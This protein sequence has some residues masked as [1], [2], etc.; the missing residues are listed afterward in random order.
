MKWFALFS[1][2]F[3]L[4]NFSTL[5][6][7]CVNGDCRSGLGT[8]I[9]RKT[10]SRYD[11]Q[12]LG[13]LRHGSGIMYFVNGDVYKGDWRNDKINGLGVFHA[14]NGDR[15]EGEFRDDKPH[16]Q[17]RLVKSNGTMQ[18]GRWVEGL[19]QQQQQQRTEQGTL[20]SS[21]SNNNNNNRQQQPTVYQTSAKPNG[22]TKSEASSLPD[23]TFSN[24]NNIRGVYYYRDGSRFEGM[25]KNGKPEGEGVC[26]YVNRDRYVG[27]WTKHAPHGQGILYYANGEVAGGRWHFGRLI[28][29]TSNDYLV[30]NQ[31]VKRDNDKSIK[32]W[33]VVIGIAR[34]S[35]M[36][37]LKYSDDD[38]YQ[39]YAFLKSPEGGAVP[40]KQIKVLIDEDATRAKILEGLRQT[41]LKADENDVVLIYYSG[42]G[43][44]GA[45]VPIDFDG[46]NNL[47]RHDEVKS[48]LSQ[49]QAKHK[50]VFADACH[51]G[52]MLL[53]SKSG[54]QNTLDKY[55][56][57]FAE[58]SGGMA[59]MMSSK[60]EETSLEASNLRQGVYSHFLIRGIKGEA[61]ANRDKLVTIS[62]LYSFLHSNV[63][64][65]T[66][67][68][69]TPTLTGSF[70]P[71]MPVSVI[72]N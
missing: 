32:V 50:I 70:D 48:I 52:S 26:Y 18:T 45:F 35:H 15:Y 71:D 24:C 51:S 23:C 29:K 41:L 30:M 43:L 9:Y 40:D 66:L 31:E 65:Y 17:G 13:G 36:Q 58:S 56:N 59:L 49:S 62:E 46:Y 11:G 33:A 63:S 53:A 67:N 54:F 2:T 6:A 64:K 37:T 14:A 5:Q 61:D 69:Q 34:Y 28:D 47:V 20:A 57:A 8:Y 72:R 38:A 68:A 21:S 25:F 19:Y 7:Q 44:D 4:Q 22:S 3:L 60:S 16:G 10:G 12:F 1:L 39:I 55:Y 42:H 27:G